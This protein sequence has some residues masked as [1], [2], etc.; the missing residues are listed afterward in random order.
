MRSRDQRIRLAMDEQDRAAH[1][2]HVIP[3]VEVLGDSERQELADYV[4]CHILDRRISA[5]EDE[6]A[7]P[8][9]RS[10]RAGG[11]GAHRPPEDN[12]LLRGEAEPALTH[13]LHGMLEAGD[14]ARS[15]LLIGAGVFR[16]LV[17]LPV[18]DLV[19][20]EAVARVLHGEE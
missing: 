8:V 20:E 13:W 19:R 16:P 9:S 2:R 3:I 4:L 10:Q 7:G 17:D 6:A 14:R 12:D 15:D 11:A 1:A 18:L 5:H